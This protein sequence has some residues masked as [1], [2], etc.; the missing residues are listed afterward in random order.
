VEILTERDAQL[1]DDLKHAVESKR[2][3]L[4]DKEK[5]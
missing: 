2:R 1:L 5:A 3:E 4:R